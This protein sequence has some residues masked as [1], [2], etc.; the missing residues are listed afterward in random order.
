MNNTKVNG[1]YEFV[2]KNLEDNLRDNKELANNI[3]SSKVIKDFV[4]INMQC[5]YEEQI[6]LTRS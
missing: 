4:E 5:V 2:L 1:N 3:D 6:I